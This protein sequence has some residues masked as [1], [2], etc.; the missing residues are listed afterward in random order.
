MQLYSFSALLLGTRFMVKHVEPSPRIMSNGLGNETHRSLDTKRHCPRVLVPMPCLEVEK[1]E[2]SASGLVCWAPPAL[3]CPRPPSHSTWNE[4]L[5]EEL[6][7]GLVITPSCPQK[8]TGRAT[9]LEGVIAVLYPLA[10]HQPQ[11]VGGT[12]PTYGGDQRE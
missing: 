3:L 10:Y 5:F 1:E 7:Y 11:T 4:H 8:D 12:T 2:L 9:L 6:T